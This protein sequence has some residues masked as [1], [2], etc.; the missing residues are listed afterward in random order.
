MIATM[1]AKASGSFLKKAPGTRAMKPRPSGSPRSNDQKSFA[2]FLQKRRPCFLATPALR[3][4]EDIAVSKN[5]NTQKY[6]RST[7]RIADIALDETQEMLNVAASRLAKEV[8]ERPSFNG[9][10]DAA[11]TRCFLMPPP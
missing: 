10:N 7:M 4:S 6:L 9:R 8:S 3:Q 11:E 2:S 1:P 5:I